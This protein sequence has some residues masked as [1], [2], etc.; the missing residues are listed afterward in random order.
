MAEIV[1]I[2]KPGKVQLLGRSTRLTM[3]L[4]RLLSARAVF[5]GLKRLHSQGELT[6]FHSDLESHNAA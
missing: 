5:F 1:F 6:R 4:F 3:T 2:A